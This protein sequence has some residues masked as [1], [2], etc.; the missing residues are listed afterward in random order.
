M[1]AIAIFKFTTC[2]KY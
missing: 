2:L 1:K